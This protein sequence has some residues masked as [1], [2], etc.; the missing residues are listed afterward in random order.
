M[1]VELDLSPLLGTNA[2]SAANSKTMA[3]KMRL[4]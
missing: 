1:T 2:S 4:Q 3:T